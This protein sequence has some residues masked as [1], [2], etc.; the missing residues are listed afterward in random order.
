MVVRTFVLGVALIAGGTVNA[1]SLR[2]GS[3]LVN[4]SATVNELIQK[5]GQPQSRN[6]E[7]EDQYAM[8]P[9][10]GARTKTGLQTVKERW[11]YKPTPGA[12]PMAVQIVDGRIVSISRAD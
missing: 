11:I 7:K 8:N 6:V 5:C 10:T 1:D 3:K 2:C 4:E 9:N 12:L